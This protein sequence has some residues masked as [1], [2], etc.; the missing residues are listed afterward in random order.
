MASHPGRGI[1]TVTVRTAAL[2]GEVLPGPCVAEPD[3]DALIA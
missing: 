2:T 1:L 3:P